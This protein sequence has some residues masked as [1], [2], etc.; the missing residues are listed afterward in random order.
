MDFI[1]RAT[2]NT[3]WLAGAIRKQEAAYRARKG[4]DLD[5][6]RAWWTPPLSPLQA[7][8]LEKRQIETTL[9]LNALVSLSDHDNIEAGQHL[10]VLD[11]TRDCPISV[12]WTAPF[13]ETFF[14]IGLHNL[15]PQHAGEMMQA[16]AQFT[17]APD[18]CR[19]AP[20]LEWAASN[21][22]T[23]V[24]LNHPMWDENH[25]G[26][27]A[28]REHLQELLKLALPF[29]HAFELNGLR[30]WKENQE[31]A[32]IA[33]ALGRP[34]ISGGD[35]HGFEPNACINLTN[36]GSFPEFVDDIRRE[37][38]SD[39]LFLPQYR[40]PLR[41]RILQNMCSILEDD[42]SHALGWTRWSDRVFYL[43]DEG[44][45][46]PLTKLWNGSAPRVVNRFV[47]L[48]SLLRHK[49]VQSALRRALMDNQEFAL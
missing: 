44:D 6:K 43:T 34:I 35:R 19:I 46:K 21:P 13:R 41:M 30:P 7:W 8:N 10:R 11:E 32:A 1:G 42:P 39:V 2:R 5:L 40:E 4:R 15:G 14:H 45:E 18:E 25:I 23:L 24:V 49:P 3:P 36:A 33:G 20:L 16:L 37:G 38:W 47:G 31:T 22:E 27:A 48:V 17:A 9:D 29:V 28:H 12:E 26:P